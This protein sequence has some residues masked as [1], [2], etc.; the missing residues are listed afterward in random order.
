MHHRHKVDA[1]SGTALRLGEAAA[2]GRGRALAECAVYAREGVTGE[3]KA[4]HHRLRHAAR[5]RRRRR[6]HGDLRRRRASGSSSRTRRR[7][8]RTS[9][10]A[11]CA[12]RISSPRAAR[13]AAPASPTCRTC[14]GS[15]VRDG[16]RRIPSTL[17]GT[18]ALVTGRRLRARASRSPGAWRAPARASCSTAATATSSPRPPQALAREGIAARRRAVRR[19]RRRRRRGAASRRVERALGPDRHPRQQRGDEPA[20]AARA[21]HAGRMARAAWR[22]ISTARS[23]SRA[24]CCRR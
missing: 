20:Q 19:D 10:P 6:A 9:P 17:P 2:R 16:A 8:G 21:V 13:A 1:P 3:R 24:R 4:G 18:R 7:R 14:S 23:S 22:R 12:P 15:A 11:R 5:R